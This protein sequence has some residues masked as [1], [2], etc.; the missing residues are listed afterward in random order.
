MKAETTFFNGLPCVRLHGANGARALVAL[1][2]AYVLSWIPADGRERLFLSERA[3]LAEGAA[4]RGGVPVIFPQFAGR[5]PLPKHGFARTLPWRLIGTDEHATFELTDGPATASWPHAFNA[6]VHVALDADAVE[7]TLEIANAGRD[8]FAFTAALHTY[9]AVDDIEAVELHGLGG[10][11]YEDSVE[12]GAIRQQAH[13]ALR[14]AGEVDRI[15]VAPSQ[16][17]ALRAGSHLTTIAQRGFCDTVVWNP[18]ATLA[19]GISDLAPDDHRR[20]VC[21]EA[22]QVLQ[23]VRLAPGDRWT[24]TQQLS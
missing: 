10:C 6:R 21:V 2:G 14:F 11:Q 5:G 15:Y 12:A 1:H 16:P 9:L 19:A 4:I 8:T 20:F 22:G 24:G 23:P 18:G 7:I 17:L 3:R 13:D